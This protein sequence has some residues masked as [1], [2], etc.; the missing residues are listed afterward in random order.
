MELPQSCS[1]VL[2]CIF[3]FLPF[4]NGGPSKNGERK[5]QQP[6]ARMGKKASCTHTHTQT[7]IQNLDNMVF[8]FVTGHWSVNQ[9]AQFY[10]FQ[11]EKANM[12]YCAHRI[13][14]KMNI[15]MCVQLDD[16]I[17]ENMLVYIGICHYIRGGEGGY[18]ITILLARPI[19]KKGVDLADRRRSTH[20]E[21]NK[22]LLWQ[23]RLSLLFY[24]G[25]LY[26]K[27]KSL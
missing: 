6:R 11:Y 1:F 21:W 2:F 17:L 15:K 27:K 13:G 14:I 23:L 12:V 4:A 18:T 3:L 19:A 5:K 24:F 22:K 9:L 10:C 16:G 20:I 26:Q 7:H 25:W 8:R